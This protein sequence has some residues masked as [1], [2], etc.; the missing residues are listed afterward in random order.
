LYWTA[1]IQIDSRSS[2]ESGK[3][4]GEGRACAGSVRGW[5]AKGWWEWSFGEGLDAIGGRERKRERERRNKAR[6]W[7]REE[8]IS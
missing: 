2:D 7:A 5:C 8:G 3:G 4:E 6:N 1:V